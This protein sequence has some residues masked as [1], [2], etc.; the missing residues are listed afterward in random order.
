MAVTAVFFAALSPTVPLTNAVATYVT[1]AANSQTLIKR[2]VV[3]NIT[4]GAI[5]FDLWRVP[6]GGSVANGNLMLK[7]QSVPAN[8]QY[9]LPELANLVLN[10]GDTIQIQASANTSLNFTASGFSA[11]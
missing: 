10:P 3:T 8:G 2:A 1:A 7:T 4:A 9:L 6:S 5:T 11:Q